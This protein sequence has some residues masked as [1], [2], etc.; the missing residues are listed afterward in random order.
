MSV[1]IRTSATQRD[2]SGSSTI[3]PAAARAQSPRGVAEIG[4]PGGLV[5]PAAAAHLH[6][7]QSRRVWRA[8]RGDHEPPLLA[9]FCR[10]Y[11]AIRLHVFS[12]NTEHVAEGV[13]SGR[14]GLGLIEGPPKRRDLKVQPWF[15]DE[16][17][18]VVPAAHEWASLG[19]ISPEGLIGA[20]LVMRELGSGSRH[21][22]ADR[23]G[24]RFYRG[25]L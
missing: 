24:A 11:P 14:F 15:D 6:L 3:S 1:S 16:L 5:V 13:A 18:L 21:I 9:D 4:R 19:V 23:D 7:I 17:L 20:P 22:A 8:L 12:E 25:Y 2:T 10:A